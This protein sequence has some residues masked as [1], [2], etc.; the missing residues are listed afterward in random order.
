MLK[1]FH[2]AIGGALGTISRYVLGGFV[3]RVCG[4]EFPYGT[5]AVNLSGCFAIGFLASI[6][7]R[8]FFFG[9]DVRTFWMIGFCGAF[10]TFPTLI[11]ETDNLIRDGQIVRACAN[12]IISVIFGFIL[13]RVGALIAEII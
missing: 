7:E 11:L 2:L 5:L 10:T 4:M 6:A 12:I 3:Y 13:F 1:F 8:K 9:S